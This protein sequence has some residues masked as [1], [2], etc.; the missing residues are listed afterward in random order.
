MDISVEIHLAMSQEEERGRETRD[1][2]GRDGVFIFILI[3]RSVVLCSEECGG[4][5]TR[6]N[7]K[8]LSEL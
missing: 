4:D 2:G 3:I 5:W 8:I 7:D 6:E 1:I